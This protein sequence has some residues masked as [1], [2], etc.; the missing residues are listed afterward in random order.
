MPDFIIKHLQ[1]EVL[2][3]IIYKATNILNGKVYIGQTTNSLEYRRSQHIREA[4][5]EKRKRPYFHNA[6]VKYGE[7]NFVFETIDTA[8]TIDEL[9]AKEQWWIE[10]YHSTDKNYGYNLDSGGKNCTKSEETKRK[11]SECK[12]E[13]WKDE[14]V[15]TRM[16]QGLRAGVETM[17]NKKGSTD[18]ICFCQRCGA[19]FVV[20]AYE[21]KRRKFCSNECANKTNIQIATKTAANKKHNDHLEF[22]KRVRDDILDWAI[23]NKD[24]VMSCPLNKVSSVYE[25]LRVLISEKYKIKDFRVMI[26]CVIGNYGRKEFAEYLKSFVMKKIYAV[27][28]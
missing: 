2:T 26:A 21:A 17:K 20:P 12:K 1:N 28:V 27:P 4:K 22:E 13:L 6:I 15:A 11:I 24:L 18:T 8:S 7:S 25:P 23:Q 9:N 14:S 3:I 10:F 19:E 16:R 5:D